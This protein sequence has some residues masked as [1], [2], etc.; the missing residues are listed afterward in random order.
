MRNIM[1]RGSA[2]LLLVGML[3]SGCGGG[4]SAGPVAQTP[5]P[6]PAPAPTA[7]AGQTPAGVLTLAKAP[8][9]TDDPL[10]VG[11]DAIATADLNDEMSDPLPAT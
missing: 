11:T 1:L 8:T 5:M 6:M 10:A 9:E 2:G 4:S 7:I 3:L